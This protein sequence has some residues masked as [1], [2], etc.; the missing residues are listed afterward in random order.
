MRIYDEQNCELFYLSVYAR[1][2]LVSEGMII[3]HILTLE[4]IILRASRKDIALLWKLLENGTT[5]QQLN[6]VLTALENGSDSLFAVLVG[7]GMIE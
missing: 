7:K 4:E 3:S 6:D 5:M 1:M 2:R